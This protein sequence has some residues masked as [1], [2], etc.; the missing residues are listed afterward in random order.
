MSLELKGIHET[1]EL[2]TTSSFGNAFP[3]AIII[4]K[5]Y[6]LNEENFSSNFRFILQLFHVSDDFKH[7]PILYLQDAIRTRPK[8][9]KLYKSLV[10]NLIKEKIFSKDDFKY[11][12]ESDYMT[13]RYILENDD[14]PALQEIINHNPTQLQ[15]S[16]S[17][18][19]F[20]TNFTLLDYSALFGSIKCFKILLLNEEI[21]TC[22]TFYWAVA[23]GSNDIL[24]I[25]EEKHP[26]VIDFNLYIKAA[27]KFHHPI[28]FEMLINNDLTY[29]IENYQDYLYNIY[30]LSYLIYKNNINK[31]NCDEFT[32]KVYLQKCKLSNY[33]TCCISNLYKEKIVKFPCNNPLYKVTEIDLF[34]L[35]DE[36]NE[37]QQFDEIKRQ[38]LFLK[39][40]E[41]YLKY[42]VFLDINEVN[43]I[44]HNIRKIVI[45]IPRYDLLIK[46][47]QNICNIHI[48]GGKCDEIG[49]IIILFYKIAMQDFIPRKVSINS[50]QQNWT[51]EEIAF[52]CYNYCINQKVTSEVME[53][54][55]RSITSG[56]VKI[57]RLK[58]SY[59]LSQNL[60]IPKNITIPEILQGKDV[61][62]NMKISLQINKILLSQLMEIMNDTDLI[63]KFK[64]T[65]KRTD[66]NSIVKKNIKQ[67]EHCI[68]VL[69]NTLTNLTKDN[70]A[71]RHVMQSINQ[72]NSV[73]LTL[74]SKTF[75]IISQ[76]FGL[77]S[78]SVA[79]KNKT[80]QLS[81]IFDGTLPKFDGEIND[82]SNLFNSYYLCSEE[83]EALKKG[84]VLAIDAA[85]IEPSV[86]IHANG[87]IDG[88][89]G[90]TK[91]SPEKALELQ[92]KEK[93][94]QFYAENEKNII[95]HVF[96][97]I[98]CPFDTRLHYLPLIR[99][100]HV[101]G[102]GNNEI[103][104]TL[105]KIRKLITEDLNIPIKG[106]AFD[107]DLTYRVFGLNLFYSFMNMLKKHDIK[108]HIS[109]IFNIILCFYY[110]SIH[111][112]KNDRSKMAKDVSLCIWPTTDISFSHKIICDF[113]IVN[114]KI[115]TK[116]SQEAQHDQYPLELYSL[117]TLEKLLEVGRTDIAFSLLPNTLVLTS[118]FDDNLSRIDRINL[119]TLSATYI[120]MY[121]ME[122]HHIAFH[123]KYHQQPQNFK[124]SKSDSQVAYA[125]FSETWAIKFFTTTYSIITQLLDYSTSINMAS[126]GSNLCEH[127]FGTNR[128]LAGTDKTL[129]GF[130]RALF[131]T[132][133]HNTFAQKENIN[134]KI[135]KRSSTTEAHIPAEENINKKDLISLET[136]MATILTFLEELHIETFFNFKGLIYDNTDSGSKSIFKS[137]SDLITFLKE[138][139]ATLREKT[140]VSFK[141]D[142]ILQHNGTQ[143]ENLI[144]QNLIHQ[145]CN[146]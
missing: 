46:E 127:C 14:L 58:R 141:D 35:I 12:E 76:F 48:P 108:C 96:L 47:L 84:G 28:K 29:T 132:V 27:I 68:E 75:S 45:S 98:F 20:N 134:T 34:K 39:N 60:D 80:E 72:L 70:P 113:N 95:S 138:N 111:L 125:R 144:Q 74:G 146:N 42:I 117:S 92:D 78:R 85:S 26:L 129:I 100:T 10:H 126:L 40:C 71:K 31:M 79:E 103:T 94:K 73:L 131:N 44:I 82:L 24:K 50:R 139:T 133:L 30:F 107:G 1:L 18:K 135:N 55:Q 116:N 87:K 16:I 11:H 19:M 77:S 145:Y 124:K 53:K 114:E 86:V 56:Q 123:G 120:L 36:K 63:E 102:F 65:T 137:L 118:I 15:E 62:E 83:K 21:P 121:M 130:N 57:S 25:I 143:H 112:S 93:R 22:T 106:L 64:E 69:I 52:L 2:I 88:I 99:I 37:N 8:T 17:S 3:I 81:K 66:A 101:S 110:D 140:K 119:L 115:F 41:Y 32:D 6:D 122:R 33:F 43:E 59:L 5:L 104:N 38:T 67:T 105:L 7:I 49:K 4:D 97:I 9:G 89:K 128:Y 136:A 13:L 23:G 109:E 61:F 51:I 54:L 142:Y 90:L 91:I